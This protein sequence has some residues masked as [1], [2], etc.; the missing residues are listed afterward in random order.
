[1]FITRY[2]VFWSRQLPKVCTLKWLSRIQGMSELCHVV[3]GRLNCRMQRLNSKMESSGRNFSMLVWTYKVW[4]KVFFDVK[5]GGLCYYDTKLQVVT[6][7]WSWSVVEQI[8]YIYIFPLAIFTCRLVALS[9]FLLFVWSSCVPFFLPQIMR[10]LYL[11]PYL[12]IDIGI[13]AQQD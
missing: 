13:D 4:P 7:W 10:T 12:S 3:L 11:T 1:M 2:I 5:R 9:D 8:I 6:T